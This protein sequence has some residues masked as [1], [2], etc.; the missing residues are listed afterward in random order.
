M[1]KGAKL[2]FGFVIVVMIATGVKLLWSA[3]A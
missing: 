3:V 2:I 1:K